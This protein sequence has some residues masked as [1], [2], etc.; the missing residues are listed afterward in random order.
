[1][2]ISAHRL[3]YFGLLLQ[4]SRHRCMS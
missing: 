3:Q 2:A 4:Q 1:L